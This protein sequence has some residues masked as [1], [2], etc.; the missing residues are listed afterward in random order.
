M[1]LKEENPKWW[2]TLFKNIYSVIRNAFHRV[3]S[4]VTFIRKV[5]TFNTWSQSRPSSVTTQV[6]KVMGRTTAYHSLVL[7]L[8]FEDRSFKGHFCFT[9]E[10]THSDLLL[11]IYVYHIITAFSNFF[12]KC[13]APEIRATWLMFHCAQVENRTVLCG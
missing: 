8:L 7:W 4:H 12:V 5:F 6:S 13:T 11:S 10:N 9:N 2:E 1:V 3:Q